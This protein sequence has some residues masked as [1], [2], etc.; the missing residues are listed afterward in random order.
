VLNIAFRSTPCTLCSDRWCLYMYLEVSVSV[1]I[2]RRRRRLY[3]VSLSA[4]PFAS[5]SVYSVESV[6]ALLSSSSSAKC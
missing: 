4:F 5:C 1:T 2:S 6:L 3:S